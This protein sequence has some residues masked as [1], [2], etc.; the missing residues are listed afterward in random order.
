M[1]RLSKGSSAGGINMAFDCRGAGDDVVDPG[2]A[3][4]IARDVLESRCA[5]IAEAV[6][7]RRRNTGANR[8]N[9]I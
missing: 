7:A 3:G 1:S 2:A 9:T 8:T 6:E 5:D 4:S